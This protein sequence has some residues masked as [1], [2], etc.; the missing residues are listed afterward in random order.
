MAKKSTLMTKKALEE[1][2][3]KNLDA[4]ISGEDVTEKPQVKKTRMNFMI[5]ED[6]HTAFKLRAVEKRVSMSEILCELIRRELEE[7]L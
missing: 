6:L 2:K 7:D 4:F 3:E 5:D 1:S